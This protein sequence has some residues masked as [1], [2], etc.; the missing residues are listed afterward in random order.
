MKIYNYDPFT[1]IFVS[2]E[3]ADESP[4]EPGVYLIPA[5][6][7]TLQPP[8]YNKEKEFCFFNEDK[9]EIKDIPIPIEDDK[10]D[11]DYKTKNEKILYSIYILYE[12]TYILGT[13]IRYISLG[14]LKNLPKSIAVND[15][16]DSLYNKYKELKNNLPTNEA[17]T[18]EYIDFSSCGEIPYSM[19]EVIEEVKKCI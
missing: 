3:N 1:K 18:K 13:N 11:I 12:N 15:W 19:E 4:L 2:E 10:I 17:V 8:E 7:T 6:A 5:H 9:W 16:L 14:L